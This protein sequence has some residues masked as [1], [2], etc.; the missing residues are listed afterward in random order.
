MDVSLQANYNPNN[1]PS[2][3]LSIRVKLTQRIHLR[4]NRFLLDSRS[5]YQ[6]PFRS[7]Q[8]RRSRFVLIPRDSLVKV[9][10]MA[11]HSFP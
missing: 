3:H 4:N 2:P 8:S 5:S 7:S 11:W 1:D 6:D 10:P 9:N